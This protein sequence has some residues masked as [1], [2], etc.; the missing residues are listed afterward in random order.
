M[1]T[2]NNRFENL[3]LERL[4]EI[5][6]IVS[7]PVIT[8]LSV[9]STPITGG[10]VGRILFQGTGNV[11]QESAN[12]TWNNSTQIFNVIGQIIAKG[13]TA[14]SLIVEGTTGVNSGNGGIILKTSTGYQPT[15]FVADS[16]AGQGVAGFGI[17]SGISIPFGVQTG[18]GNGSLFIHSNGNIGIGTNYINAGYKLDVNGTVRLSTIYFNG[19]AATGNISATSSSLEFNTPTSFGVFNFNCGGGGRRV[20]INGTA[21]DT[22]GNDLLSIPFVVQNTT[23]TGRNFSM[24]N[25]NPTI[26]NTAAYTGT[27]R[28]FYYNPTITSLTGTIHRA[29]ETTTGDVL[30]GA[31]GTGFFWDNTNAR[32]GI[33]TNAPTTGIQVKSASGVTATIKLHTANTATGMTL[34]YG[35][36]DTGSLTY[37]NVF[38]FTRNDN[39]FPLYLSANSNVL[40]NS[41]TDAG[42]KLDV[43]GTARVSGNM[44]VAGVLSI[45]QIGGYFAA[46]FQNASDNFYGGGNTF[47]TSGYTNVFWSQRN[48]APTSGTA[49]FN[50]FIFDSTINQTG[51]A[52]GITR[53]LY[54]NPTLTSAADFRAIEVASGITILGASTTAKASLRIPSGTAPTSPVN[55]DIWFDGTN[56]KMRIGG[57]TKTFTLI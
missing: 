57:V 52:N 45:Q 15:L 55:G 6:D 44:Q 37:N 5:F 43:N 12:L 13:S 29:I 48:F 46:S 56:I 14:S 31:S 39:T 28:G 3:T 34:R 51:G 22:V 7:V 1:A 17:Y 53:G 20:S 16:L 42:F 19:V 27:V 25:I 2:I 36:S 9:G 18:A 21:S 24:L 38:Y 26:N 41:L 47:L 11:L 32:L 23:G 40:I 30:F 8:T 49:I 33:G 50:G 54:I 10:A 35:D 4:Q